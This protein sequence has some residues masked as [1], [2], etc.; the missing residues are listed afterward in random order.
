[1]STSWDQLSDKF[2]EL[3]IEKSIPLIG[4]FEL[5]S[6][7]NLQC[8]MC[9]VC[10]SANDKMAISREHSA[11]EWM[12]LVEKARDAGMLYLLFTGGEVF[13]RQV[14]REIYENVSMM[15]L[16]VML[17]TNG[18]LI[19]PEIAKWLGR[20]PPSKVEVTLYGASPETYEKV[21]GNPQGFNQAISGIDL[22][23]SEGI[24]L[25]IRTTVVK[26]NASDFDKIAEI[27]DNRGVDLGIV[28]YISPRR[29]GYRTYPE[30]ERLASKEL[31]AYINNVDDY[32]TSKETTGS[33]SIKPDKEKEKTIKN[34]E[35]A[36]EVN[37][38]FCEAGRCAFWIT[39]DGRMTPCGLMNQPEVFPFEN[40]FN[41]SWVELEKRCLE[42]PICEECSSCSLKEN[43]ICCPARL[44]NE[45]GFYNKPAE[46]LCN[47]AQYRK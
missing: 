3:A 41:Q 40:G 30:G 4:Q 31:A 26:G 32:F 14:F 38:F 21:C 7:C 13:L 28:D 35:T 18:T 37:P 20:T 27:A 22:L 29:D 19:T 1:M 34:T 16:N 42:I 36:L 47:L 9:Y 39:W 12:S 23:L 8:K 10:N 45:T 2:V 43:C 33:K 11:K 25:K 15:G 5:T 17:Y 24:G 46:Y 44:K 6:R